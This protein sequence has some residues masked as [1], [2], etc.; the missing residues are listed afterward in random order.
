MNPANPSPSFDHKEAT[1][2]QDLRIEHFLKEGF[3]PEAVLDLAAQ[4]PVLE[5][6]NHYEQLTDP[7][8]RGYDGK[9]GYCGVHAPASLTIDLGEVGADEERE[10]G[11]VQLLLFDPIVDRNRPTRIAGSGSS[12][13]TASVRGGRAIGSL[14]I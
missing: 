7:E 9:S 4:K 2:A 11:L 13:S 6:C 12:S 14:S 3:S 5:L 1:R 8:F 10:L